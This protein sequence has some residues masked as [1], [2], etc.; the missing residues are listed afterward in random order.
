LSSFFSYFNK[1][2]IGLD[3]FFLNLTFMDTNSTTY[4]KYLFPVGV[5]IAILILLRLMG[6]DKGKN[7]FGIGSPCDDKIDVAVGMMESDLEAFAEV[8]QML[9]K[10]VEKQGIDVAELERSNIRL[11]GPDSYKRWKWNDIVLAYKCLGAIRPMGR[12]LAAFRSEA[13]PSTTRL[14]NKLGAVCNFFGDDS[15]VGHVWDAIVHT[16][17][18]T[19]HWQ[20]VNRELK[21]A[22]D[23][24]YKDVNQ[25]ISKPIDTGCEKSLLTKE[26]KR[27]FVRRMNDRMYDKLRKRLGNKRMDVYYTDKDKQHDY[28]LFIKGLHLQ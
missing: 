26:E 1:K 11:S 14:M 15:V 3:N 16:K 24:F 20:K 19:A 4:G 10:E 21:Q 25:R 27:E 5:G 28:D 7:S 12:K 22:I 18:K 17:E 13:A 8:A 23:A 9:I 6:C 2:I